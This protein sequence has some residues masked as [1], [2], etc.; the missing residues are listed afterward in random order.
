MPYAMLCVQVEQHTG[1]TPVCIVCCGSISLHLVWISVLS[2]SRFDLRSA[3]S[4]AVGRGSDAEPHSGLPAHLV[5]AHY[6]MLRVSVE[7]HTGATPVCIVC[8]IF[9]ATP[10]LDLS[11]GSRL[12]L[13]SHQSALLKLHCPRKGCGYCLLIPEDGSY[14]FGYN[15]VSS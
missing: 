13:R 15:P 3:T 7:Q 8:W 6:V 12:D 2:A 11:S 14:G 10:C 4:I 9:L 5:V 1:E